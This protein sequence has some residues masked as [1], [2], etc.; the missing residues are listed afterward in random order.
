MCHVL[1]CFQGKRGQKNSSRVM[2][3][4]DSPQ[5]QCC[6]WPLL[7]VPALTQPRRGISFVPTIP[8]DPFRP[9]KSE[10]VEQTRIWWS[11]WQSKPRLADFQNNVNDTRNI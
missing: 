7:V 1:F 6:H 4:G 8:I 5:R 9:H 2:P 11:R 10:I 3:R